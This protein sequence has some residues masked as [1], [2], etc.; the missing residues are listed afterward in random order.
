MDT[1]EEEGFSD[2]IGCKFWISHSTNE[3]LVLIWEDWI[4]KILDKNLFIKNLSTNR[5]FRDRTKK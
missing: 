3:G 2:Y 4:M 5:F 1:K